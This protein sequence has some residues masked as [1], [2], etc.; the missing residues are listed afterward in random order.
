MLTQW[1]L[2]GGDGVGVGA[3]Y[4]AAV[5]SECFSGMQVMT[6]VECCVSLDCAHHPV[7][8]SS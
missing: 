3:W 7:W 6:G 2:G 8:N 5:S 1:I 4:K